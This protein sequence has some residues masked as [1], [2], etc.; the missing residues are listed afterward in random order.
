MVDW[1]R[2]AAGSQTRVAVQPAAS[3]QPRERYHPG[4]ARALS[5]DAADVRFAEDLA[6]TA[7]HD[8]GALVRWV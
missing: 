4:E 5:G 3:R 7:P 8:T 6:S 2:L 1:C